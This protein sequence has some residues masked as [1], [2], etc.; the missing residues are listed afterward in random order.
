LSGIE[1]RLVFDENPYAF[2][3]HCFAHQLQLVAV[4][5]AKCCGSVYDFF[6]YTSLIVNT[7]SASYKR[8]DQLLQRHHDKIVEELDG[9]AMFPGRGKTK[10]LVSQ[11]QGILGGAHIIRH[12]CI[13]FSCGQL[14]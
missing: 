6:N 9:G 8:K 10:K 1:K 7:V 12:W 2:Y 4:S 11:G 5:I 14:C 13:F 3:I